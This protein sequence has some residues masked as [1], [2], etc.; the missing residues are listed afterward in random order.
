MGELAQ[1][2]GAYVARVALGKDPGLLPSTHTD[3]HS[4]PAPFPLDLM[5]LLTS[6]NMQAEYSCIEENLEIKTKF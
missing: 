1:W 4:N 5:L 3:A 6:T 2:L